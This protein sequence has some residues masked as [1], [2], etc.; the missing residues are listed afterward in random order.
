M[1]QRLFALPLND[2]R[3]TARHKTVW[4]GIRDGR[5]A[6]RYLIP[7]ARS[8]FRGSGKNDAESMQLLKDMQD[9]A[10]DNL[11]VTSFID[12]NSSLFLLK[13]ADLGHQPCLDFAQSFR[14][15]INNLGEL[16]DEYDALV[17]AANKGLQHR[18]YKR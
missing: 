11:F 7:E 3:L 2:S 1:P 10:C 4:D 9:H 18:L 15:Y 12:T 16:I 8:S 17:D 13:I 14:D 6:E 5:W